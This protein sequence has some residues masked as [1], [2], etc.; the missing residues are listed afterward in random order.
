M[1]LFGCLFFNEIVCLIFCFICVGVCV[2]VFVWPFI[3]LLVC[4]GCCCCC[5]CACMCACL[6]IA[7]RPYIISTS[8]A[9]M[10]QIVVQYNPTISYHIVFKENSYRV[11][12][13]LILLEDL[14]KELYPNYKKKH[15]IINQ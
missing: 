7:S 4:V 5:M 1:C 13:K 14:Y 11:T 12:S 6:L 9:I 2:C 3:F 8:V 15:D 10:L